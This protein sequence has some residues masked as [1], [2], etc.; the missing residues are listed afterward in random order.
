M[1]AFETNLILE[2]LIA[3]GISAITIFITIFLIRL[4]ANLVI[5]LCFAGA[6]IAPLF[7]QQ[8]NSYLGNIIPMESLFV[9]SGLFAFLVTLCTIPLWPISS[10]MMRFLNKNERKR[11]ERLEQKQDKNNNSAQ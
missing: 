10:I 2:S 7:L 9:F 11:I 5:I 1:N 6:I 4:F 3:L 8:I